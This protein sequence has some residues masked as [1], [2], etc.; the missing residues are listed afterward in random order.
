MDKRVY[1][2]AAIAFVVGMVE[3]L[4]GGILDLVATDLRVSL[5]QAGLLITVFALVFSVSGPLLLFLTRRLSPKTVT[6]SALLVFMVG[7]LIT[8]MGTSYASV[9]LSR[10]V[11]AASGALLT[12]LSL[13][14]ASRI[15]APQHRG[16]AIGLVVMG[17][18]A[19]LVLGL[20]IGVS[21]GQ[22]L[23]W[24]SPFMLNL[25]L[26][27]IL[28]V[29]VK[30]W[31]GDIAIKA[32]P[33]PFA[34]IW[35]S[36]GQRRV[37]FAHLTT[38][39]FLAG[40][41]SLYGYLTPFVSSQL[42]YS[43]ALITLV[44]FIYGIAAVTGG[45]LAGYFTDR[46]SPRR[47]LLTA[48]CLL[49]GCLLLI[50]LS[51][52]TPFLFWCVLIIWGVLSWSITPPIQSHL[53]HIAPETADIHQSLNVT[54]LHLGIAFGT[55]VGSLVIDKLTVIYNGPAGAAIILLS[56]LTALICLQGNSAATPQTGHEAH[57]NN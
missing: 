16:R 30:L 47:T 19:S 1:L 33:T 8:L 56:L 17:I 18:S 10:V 27:L 45:G 7:D 25:G 32:K 48:I 54:A 3:L 46:F 50:P 13:A 36:L 21:M 42:A 11:L 6:I 9:M 41:F 28:L 26:A 40:H 37:L 22:V 2:L 12:V 14:L 43:G 39:F 55:L 31:L 24:R 4:I 23:G 5:G 34:T 20:P 57:I 49:C 51:V 52:H 35:R 53:V 44:Y 15:S 38:F 29:L